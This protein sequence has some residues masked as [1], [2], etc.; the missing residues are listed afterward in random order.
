MGFGGFLTDAPTGSEHFWGSDRWHSNYQRTTPAS[1]A[2]VW[3]VICV[4]T[5]SPGFNFQ[6][7]PFLCTAP[8]T[9]IIIIVLIDFTVR[10]IFGG[11]VS[12]L[13]MN[14]AQNHCYQWQHTSYEDT[15]FIWKLI[16]Y[17]GW[18]RW[19]SHSVKK[20]VQK[21]S[22]FNTRRH[23][24]VCIFSLE[25]RLCRNV[26]QQHVQ[27]VQSQQESNHQVQ[28]AQH[29]HNRAKGGAIL[30]SPPPPWWSV[31]ST[32]LRMVCSCQVWLYSENVLLIST[33][34]L[35]WNKKIKFHR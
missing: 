7:S 21:H 3:W 13:L 9:Q 35:T 19:V 27:R 1:R 11:V 5:N 4:Q 26:R 28:E 8:T 30:P 31:P 2:M 10:T 23:Q 12:T 22:V 16:L 15:T 34:H 6:A 17:F 33:R 18:L 14:R 29:Q 25:C 24:S 32:T 20:K